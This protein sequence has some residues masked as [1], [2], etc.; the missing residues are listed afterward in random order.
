MEHHAVGPVAARMEL[1][2]RYVAKSLSYA[3][4]L[5]EARCLRGGRAEWDAL[6]VL[7]PKTMYVETFVAT[8]CMMIMQSLNVHCIGIHGALCLMYI[9]SLVGTFEPVP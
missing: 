3:W 7:V 8:Y 6:L 2:T 4:Y 9:G 1:H 5:R